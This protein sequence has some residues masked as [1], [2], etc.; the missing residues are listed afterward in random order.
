MIRFVIPAYNEAREHPAPAG[1]PRAARPRARRARDLRR[2][3]LDRRHRRRDRGAPR[4]D[5]HLR[6]R[7]PPRST[8]GLGT[9]INSGLRAALGEAQDDDAIVTL[10]ADNTSDLDDL[11]RDA[12]ALR[13]GLR[14]R[15][16]LGLRAGRPDHRRR[17]VA[18]GGLAR[19][20]RTRS[21]TPAAC[22]R[23]T[24]SP[25][26]YRVYRAGTLRRAAETYGYLLVREPGLRRQRRAAAQA[27]QRRR[28]GRRGA[29]GQRLEPARRA[30]RR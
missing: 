3:R 20:S 11:P 24:R 1:G 27:L 5:L 7:A 13:R 12:G 19:R 2:R 26:L 25:R 9:A 23:S 15:A 21:A 22:G 14:R 10:E 6:G 28:H 17:A 18:A 30:S 8:A 16:R 4:S 29:D